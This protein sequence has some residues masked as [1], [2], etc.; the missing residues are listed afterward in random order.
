VARSVRATAEELEE[1]RVNFGLHELAV[2]D[3]QTYHLRPKI[4]QYDGDVDFVILR[5]ARYDDDREEVEFGEI[6]IFVGP[7]LRHHRAPGRR[8]R[9][10]RRPPAP[11]AAS[12]TSSR[13]GPA[14]ALWA[15]LDKVVDDYTRSSRASSATS[16]RSR[17]PCSPERSRRPSGSTP[18]AAR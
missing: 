4:E 1:V 18:C 14:A 17:R 10:A 3:A 8:E 7:E 12:R 13:A 5:T 11:R 6:S 15:I 9:P 2:E 16:R